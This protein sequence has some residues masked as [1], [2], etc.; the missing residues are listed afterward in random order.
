[1]YSY[2]KTSSVINEEPK[3]LVSSRNVSRDDSHKGN[4]VQMSNAT[5]SFE[6]VTVSS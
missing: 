1:M 6:L 3:K 2:L 5:E 4:P